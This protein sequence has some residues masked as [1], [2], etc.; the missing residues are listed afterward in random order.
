M[1]MQDTY[2]ISSH[3]HREAMNVAHEMLRKAHTIQ[4]DGSEQSL[5][6]DVGVG[7]CACACDS[8]TAQYG[9]RLASSAAAL[10]A[11]LL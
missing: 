10:T 7:V 8:V 5:G 9:G 11:R 4:V 1:A 2:C 3:A 6:K